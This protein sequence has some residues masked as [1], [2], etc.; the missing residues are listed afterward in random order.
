LIKEIINSIRKTLVN[1]LVVV[2]FQ[3]P[4]QH[5][6][7]SYAAYDKNL[8][9]RFDRRIEITRKTNSSRSKVDLLLDVKVHNNNKHSKDWSRSLLLQERDLL[10]IPDP[11]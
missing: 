9:P 2:S 7:K 11:K 10:I 3:Q 4:Q 6:N 8:L 5:N 1:T